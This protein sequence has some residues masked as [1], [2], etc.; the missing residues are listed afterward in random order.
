[1]KKNISLIIAFLTILGLIVVGSILKN[2]FIYFDYKSSENI[3]PDFEKIHPVAYFEKNIGKKD[4]ETRTILLQDSK[5][6]ELEKH[7]RTF[8]KTY[9]ISAVENIKKSR[10]LEGQLLS[11]Y[12]AFNGELYLYNKAYSSEATNQ[13]LLK[14]R[15]KEVLIDYNENEDFFDLLYYGDYYICS[16]VKKNNNNTYDTIKL[17]VVSEELEKIASVNIDIEKYGISVMDIINK[18]LIITNE[19]VIIPVKKNNKFY[20]L[21]YNIETGKSKLE[22]KKYYPIGLVYQVRYIYMLGY[23]NNKIIVE[24]ANGSGEVITSNKIDLK[25]ILKNYDTDIRFDKDFYMWE[26]KIYGCF[27]DNKKNTCVY[28]LYD[29]EKNCISKIC[30]INSKNELEF[31]M[32]SK[33]VVVFKNKLFDM[34]PYF[35]N[36]LLFNK[37]K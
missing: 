36:S 32:D 2:N 33:Y 21:F 27:Y 10:E 6:V 14:N 15:I 5:N 35:D 25:T 22:E 11:Y 30:E 18:T 17:E 1:M 24:K 9:P 12:N 26:N 16:F 8:S 4:Y 31:L 28:F 19:Y 7:Y 34:Y 20:F 29:V 3:K 37:D 23:D 13:L